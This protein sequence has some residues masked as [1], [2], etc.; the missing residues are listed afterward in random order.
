M[1][2]LCWL[3][4]SDEDRLVRARVLM[5]KG[6]F[7]DARKGLVECRAPEAEALYERCSAEVA[8]G[9]RATLKKRL[10]AEG[11]HGWKVEVAMKDTARKAALEALIT[12]ELIAAD[13]DLAAP[14]LDQD[15]VKAAFGRADRKARNRGAG[16][17]GTVRLVPIADGRSAR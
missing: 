3:F 2:L 15:A 7:E 11:F 4:P 12:K 10:A 6:R 9:D 16:G 13:I 5:A 1:G 14:D 17:A 8:K